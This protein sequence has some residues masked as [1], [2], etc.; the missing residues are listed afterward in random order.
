M[1]IAIFN[2]IYLD[3][4]E[5]WG[6]GRYYS[7][8]DK[9]VYEISS[10]PTIYLENAIKKLTS[11]REVKSQAILN[12]DDQNPEIVQIKLAYYEGQDLMALKLVE[13]EAELLK[14]ETND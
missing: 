8:S 9:K 4:Y 12:I 1:K 10:M 11:L 5:K 2:E 13:L 6:P 3:Y 14:R 7:L